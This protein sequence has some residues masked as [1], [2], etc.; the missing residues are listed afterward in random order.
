MKKSSVMLTIFMLML[1]IGCK[2]EEIIQPDYYITFRIKPSVEL[3]YELEYNNSFL[4]SGILPEN[5]WNDIKVINKG[6]NF[7][8]Y[9][10][11]KDYYVD[12]IE[13]ISFEKSNTTKTIE[14]TPN[15]LKGNATI[16]L[17]DKIKRNQYI[18]TEIIIDVNST[19][20]GL[21]YCLYWSIGYLKAEPLRDVSICN[22]KW[23]NQTKK[24]N[25]SEDRYYCNHYITECEK[26]R[27][28]ECFNKEFIIPRI[29]ADKCY[30]LGTTLSDEKLTIPVRLQSVDYFDETD[31][32]EVTLIDM[33]LR[34][35]KR[36]DGI[37]GYGYDEDSG[38]KDITKKI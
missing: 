35:D 26:I 28:T 32:I 36:I 31:Y 11:N 7:N 33:E 2:E 6:G 24:Q 14:L 12:Y 3:N 5:K 21:S 13:I 30:F 15:K 20:E 37:W 9:Y 29:Y 18:E 1:L 17:K 19:I 4:K 38:I 16:S 10:W 23:T 34:K 27:G 8:I 25:L 22:K